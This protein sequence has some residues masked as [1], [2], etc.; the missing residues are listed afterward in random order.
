M[1]P[2]EAAAE[3]ADAAA[4]AL[5]RAR[6]ASRGVPQKSRAAAARGQRRRTPRG[7]TPQPGAGRDPKSLDAVMNRLVAGRGWKEPIAVGS[8]LGKWPEIVGPE[9]AAHCVPE[10]FEGTV[11]RV[12][13]DSTAWSTQLR[14]L[15]PQILAKIDAELGRGIVTEI[16]VVGP[17]APSWRKGYW[18]VKGR[19]PRD[20]YG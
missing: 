20:T 12:R 11:V 13:T 10:N 6:A 2:G 19:G 7:E 4:T 17:Q 15:V 16:R 3:E 14:L 18:H 5:G 8:V 1:Q 9:I